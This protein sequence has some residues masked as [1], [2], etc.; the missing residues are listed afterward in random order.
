MLVRLREL[1]EMW[2]RIACKEELDWEG[3]NHADGG[4]DRL[5]LRLP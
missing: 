3:N 4:A 1:R 2:K 5:L